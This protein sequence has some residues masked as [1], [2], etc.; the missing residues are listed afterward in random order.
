MNSGQTELLAEFIIGPLLPPGQVAFPPSGPEVS[1]FQ[2]QC[3]L[4]VHRSIHTAYYLME[5][6]G[7]AKDY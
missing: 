6:L 7:M 3:S 1:R 4:K 5:V 2:F